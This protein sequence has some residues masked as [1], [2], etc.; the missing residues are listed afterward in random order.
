MEEYLKRI[1]LDIK[2]IT[3]N[4]IDN[5][6]YVPNEEN[7][8]EGYAMIIGPETTPY[9]Y[10]YYLFKFN[11]TN[12]YPYAPPKV[13]YHTNDGLTRFN[14]NFYRNGKV[15]LSIL[16]TWKG[17]KWS[18]CQSI[19]SILITLQM[20][21]NETPLLNEPGIHEISHE[22][23]IR[24][25]NEIIEYKNI[26]LAIIRYLENKENIPDKFRMFYSIMD[27]KYEEN[28]DSIIKII[29]KNMTS[30]CSESK[31][32]INIYNMTAY[33]NYEVLHNKIHMINN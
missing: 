6:Y 5:I 20:T 16:N 10:G 23:Q 30:A 4:P 3:K 31:K 7:I 15:C 26:E 14:P 13:T 28:K 25:Y 29:E 11:F 21:M 9:Q 17:E 2:D 24:T 12:K 18:S 32:F 19:R 27:E 1:I 8:C 22:R 33:C